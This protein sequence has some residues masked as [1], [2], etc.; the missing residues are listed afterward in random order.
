MIESLIAQIVGTAVATKRQVIDVTLTRVVLILAG[1]VFAVGGLAFVMVTIYHALTPFHMTP[2]EAAA[3]IAA[4]LLVIGGILVAVGLKADFKKKPE[5]P[6]KT[7]SQSAELAA[8]EA[9]GTLNKALGDIRTGRGGAS[10]YLGLLGVAAVIGFIS[11]RK[12]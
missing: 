2:V 11:G 7:D 12:R 9:L 3:V 5:N 4:V 1:A 8:L 6:G 10:P